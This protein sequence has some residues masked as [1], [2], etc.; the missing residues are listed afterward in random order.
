MCI[1]GNIKIDASSPVVVAP[2]REPGG[3]QLSPAGGGAASA[4]H[5]GRHELRHSQHQLCGHSVRA[6]DINTAD[7]KGPVCNI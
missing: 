3:E 7:V 5:V 6:P 4:E 2:R 1:I